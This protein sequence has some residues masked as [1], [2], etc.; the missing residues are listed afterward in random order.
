MSDVVAPVA[1]LVRPLADVPDP[2]FAAEMVGAGVAIE[3][4]GGMAE[5][6]SPVAG[7][8]IKLHPHAYVVVTA[9]GTGVLVHLGID[10]VKLDGDGF[11]L[12]VEVEEERGDREGRHS[13]VGHAKSESPASTVAPVRSLTTAPG[14][15]SSTQ[16]MTMGL[17]PRLCTSVGSHRVT[18]WPASTV[19]FSSTSSSKPSPSSL[20]VSMPRWTS[21]PVPSGVTTT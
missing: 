11:E 6:V 15:V 9:E 19:D 5:A 7:T 10:T 3:P 13:E 16:S 20:T 12:L 14:F 4:S 18:G 17:S 21:T 2:V 8:L 1:G